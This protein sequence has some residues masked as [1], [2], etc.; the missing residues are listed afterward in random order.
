MKKCSR[1]KLP[2]D[3]S[4]FYTKKS[5][6]DG[7]QSVCKQCMI[8]NSKGRYQHNP[9]I[10]LNTKLNA[11]RDIDKLRAIC[12]KIKQNYGC[13]FC[14]ENNPI[15]LDF[16]HLDSTT[17]EGDV[18]IFASHK[19][20]EKTINEIN[21]CLVVCANCHRKIHF[22]VLSSKKKKPCKVLM[23]DYFDKIGLKWR[24]K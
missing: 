17:K 12:D 8:T 23:T 7:Y 1:C 22:G 4:E 15:C 2:K 18:S 11:K 14:V 13:S 16:H 6:K 20:K 21:K 19:A 24:F 10:K 3:L 9:Q 5:A